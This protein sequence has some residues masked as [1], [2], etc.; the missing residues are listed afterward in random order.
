MQEYCFFQ[1]IASLRNPVL[2]RVLVDDETNPNVLTLSLCLLQIKFHNLFTL[3][4]IHL[5]QL[6][7]I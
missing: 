2:T 1:V 4:H 6:D 5:F 7:V 3:S